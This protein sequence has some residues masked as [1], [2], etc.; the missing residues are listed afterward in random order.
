[1]DQMLAFV[2]HWLVSAMPGHIY[3]L[4]DNEPAKRVPLPHHTSPP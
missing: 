4:R 3:E 1:M 2:D